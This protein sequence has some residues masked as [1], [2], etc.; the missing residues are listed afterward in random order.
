MILGGVPVGSLN[1]WLCHSVILWFCG[2]VVL[3]FCGSFCY[4]KLPT[5]DVQNLPP[6]PQYQTQVQTSQHK[7]H[8]LSNMRSNHVQ[9]NQQPPSPPTI[10]TT[11]PRAGQQQ[12]PPVPV[13]CANLA[14]S[15][16]ST[17]KSKNQPCANMPTHLP[18]SLTGWS[19]VWAGTVIFIIST[20]LLEVLKF[21]KL[22]CWC[23]LLWYL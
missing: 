6:M 7:P 19:A 11:Q 3:W 23:N 8:Y 16:P 13:T 22:Y 21:R 10:T 20:N 18:T 9:T 12:P 14:T 17:K 5:K 1:S 4:Q 15:T 2:S